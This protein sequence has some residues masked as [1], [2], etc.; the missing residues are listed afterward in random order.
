MT[1]QRKST[2]YGMLC[3]FFLVQKYSEEL[4]VEGPVDARGYRRVLNNI[5]EIWTMYCIIDVHTIR[6]KIGVGIERTWMK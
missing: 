3:F 2:A 6:N 5:L 1:Y 4:T